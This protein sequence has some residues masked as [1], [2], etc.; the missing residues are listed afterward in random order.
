MKTEFLKSLIPET[1]EGRDEII[2]KIFA[3]NGEDV[4][5]AKQP[6]SDYDTIKAQ[7]TEAQTTITTLKASAGDAATLRAKLDEYEQK[8]AQ[9]VE[10]EAKSAKQREIA[11]RFATVRGAAKFVEPEV[12]EAVMAKF[13][14]ALSDEAFKGK[15]DAEIYAALTKDKKF[16]ES[17]NPPV[18]MGGLGDTGA[19]GAVTPEQ[20]AKMGVRERSELQTKQPELYTQLVNL[21]RR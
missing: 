1:V 20:F 10:N 2:K 6:F 16:F 19:L 11:Q 18:N 14:A 17:Q 9:R 7:L 5:K 4:E 12:E 3:A 13:G 21:K 15:G 8:E